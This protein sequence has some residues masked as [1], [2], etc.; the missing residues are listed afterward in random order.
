MFR[1]IAGVTNCV[2][3]KAIIVEAK[4]FGPLLLKANYLLSISY[5]PASIIHLGLYDHVAR[6]YPFLLSICYMS[7]SA[8][9]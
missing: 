4:L 2:Y 5:E 3:L 6:I 8:M 9:T 7:V 1:I